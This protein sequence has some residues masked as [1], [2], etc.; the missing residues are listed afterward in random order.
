M[1]THAFAVNRP[2]RMARP[3][4]VEVFG[5]VY[6]HSPWIAE[7][8]WELGP[9]PGPGPGHD[10]GADRDTAEGIHEAFRTVVDRAGREKQLALLRAHPDLA[11]RLAIAGELTAASN[12]EQAGADL[13]NCTPDEFE[14]FQ[15]LNGAHRDKFGF[16]F[17]LAVRGFHR[18]EIL[19]IFRERVNNDPETE[20]ATALEQVHR[21]A[22]LRLRDI[23]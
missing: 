15:A 7:T 19:E 17:I 18:T 21:I 5:G 11:G 4:F 16:P 3:E 23:E 1:E 20:F 22:L 9:G 14:E 10:M 13:G 2:S 12:A 8:V 6:E